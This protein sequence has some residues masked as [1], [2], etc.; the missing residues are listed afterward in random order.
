MAA[1]RGWAAEHGHLL[2]PLDATHQGYRVG[3]WLMNQQA[4]A[5][6]R[7]SSSG[8]PKACR[9]SRRPGR[10]RRSG[11]NSWRTSTPLGARP[12]PWNGNAASTWY[13]YTWRPAASCPRH[14][15]RSC[16]RA[17]TSADGY[18]RSASA[19]TAS[20]PRNSGCANTSSACGGHSV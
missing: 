4:A 17:R 15:A 2:V 18:A 1:A 19:G 8:G 3:I 7:R 12:D 16:T 11:A 5:G 14:R 13:G 20:P 6:P 10:C 9:F